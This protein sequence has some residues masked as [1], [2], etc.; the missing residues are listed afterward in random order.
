MNA[1]AVKYVT[2]MLPYGLK[3][4]SRLTTI[5]GGEF[6]VECCLTEWGCESAWGTSKLVKATPNHGGIKFVGQKEASGQSGPYAAYASIDKFV[7]DY[8]RVLSLS[9]YNCIRDAC[10]A[11]YPTRDD[12]IKAVF[13]AI[14]QSPYAESHYSA[15]GVPGGTLVNFYAEWA[16]GV[17]VKGGLSAVEIPGGVGVFGIPSGLTTGVVIVAILAAVAAV[18]AVVSED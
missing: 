18:A 12:R 15:G 7:D 1:Q 2:E 6:P 11:T 10:R 16:G 17:N 5:Y 14:G 4:A 3:A 13:K 8:V 9:Y